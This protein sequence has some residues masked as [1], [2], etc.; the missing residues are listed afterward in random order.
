MATYQLVNVCFPSFTV[1]IYWQQM[2]FAALKLI[3]QNFFL[4]PQF[5]CETSFTKYIHIIYV[6]NKAIV[7]SAAM[8][9]WFLVKSGAIVAYVCSGDIA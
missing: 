5:L 6:T 4:Q 3:V 7:L 8:L 9:A 1:D 2:P